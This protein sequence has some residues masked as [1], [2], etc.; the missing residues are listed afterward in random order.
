MKKWT[1]LWFLGLAVLCQGCITFANTARTLLVQPGHFSDEWD[2]LITYCLH[3]RMAKDALKSHASMHPGEHG[4]ADFEAGFLDGYTRY[5]DKGGA[6][7]PPPVPPRCYWRVKYR[8][9]EGRQ[10]VEEYFAG[11]RTGSAAAMASGFRRV[12]TIASSLPPATPRGALLG[13][14][15]TEPTPQDIPPDLALPFPRQIMSD[16][17]MPPAQ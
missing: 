3:R 7:N 8:T 11:F 4:T 14:A 10:A 16:G 6:G 13:W 15:T 1:I 9:P 17:K 12:D 5:L 2:R